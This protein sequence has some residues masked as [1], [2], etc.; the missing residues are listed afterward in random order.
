MR[1][2]ARETQTPGWDASLYLKYADERTRPA[3]DLLAQVPITDPPRAYDLGCGPGNSTELLA[4]RFPRAAIV[5]IDSSAAMLERARRALPRVAFEMADLAAWQAPQPADLLFS[6]AAFQ[7]VPDHLRVLCT[8]V[9]ALPC[10]GI[11]AVQIPDNLGEPSQVLIRE[12]AEHGAW[13]ERLAD[14]E[15]ERQTIPAPAVYYELLAPLCRHFDLWHTVY[16]HVMAGAPAIVEWMTGTGLRPHL[17]RL[18]ANERQAF[19]AAYTERI[20]AAYPALDDGRVLFP[21]PRLFLIAVK[22]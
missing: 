22:A 14:A 17:A 9:E 8:L 12:I 5:G 19:L 7:W 10:G 20:A 3:R 4:T 2:T 13:A 18:Q 15:G 11:L 6:N 21:F 16:Q 1:H